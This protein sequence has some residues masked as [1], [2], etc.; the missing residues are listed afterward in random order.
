MSVDER[1]KIMLQ[2]KDVLLA[3]ADEL[4]YIES[5]NA[6][7]TLNYVKNMH[8][9]RTGCRIHRRMAGQGQGKL[10]IVPRYS[11]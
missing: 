10:Q 5:L 4:A 3:H 7:L 2:I 1:K 9:Q 8:V 11:F 6:G